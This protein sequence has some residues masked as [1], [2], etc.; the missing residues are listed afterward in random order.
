MRDWYEIEDVCEELNELAREKKIVHVLYNRCIGVKGVIERLYPDDKYNTEYAVGELVFSVSDDD[1]EVE[2]RP[3]GTLFIMNY[4]PQP[5]RLLGEEI[6]VYFGTCHT[7]GVL[8]RD[9][10]GWYKVNNVHFQAF[11]VN[12][13]FLESVY[14]P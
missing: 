10:Q 9:G 4:G 5:Y 12:H 14:I 11:A 6:D 13:A 8:E 2:I 1:V 7:R 3:D